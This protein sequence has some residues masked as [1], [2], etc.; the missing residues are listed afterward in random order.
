M[1][2]KKRQ[3]NAPSQSQS[4]KKSVSK[5]DMAILLCFIAVTLVVFGAYRFFITQPYFQVVFFIYLAVA[6][7]SILTYVIYNRGFSR[8][9]LTKDM[10]PDDWSDEKKQEFIED[11]KKRLKRSRP[12][13]ILCFAFAFTFLMDIIELYCIP[14][15]WE[16]FGI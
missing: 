11:G 2:K 13:L 15:L 7:V 9:G 4:H 14:F 6:T 3:N 1:A 16:L 5:K 8:R 12:L 10:L